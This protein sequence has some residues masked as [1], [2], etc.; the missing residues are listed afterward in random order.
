MKHLRSGWLLVLMVVVVLAGLM[1]PW[2][3]ADTPPAG[4][5][6]PVVVRLYFRDQAH[7]NAVAGELDIWEVHRDA[8]YVVAALRPAEYQWLQ[9]LGYRLEI[10]AEKT[11]L[12]GIQAPLDPRYYYF[13]DYFANS[14]NR[15]IVNFLQDTNAAYPDLTE[16]YDIGNA[17]EGDHGG[18]LRDM[19]VLR[20]TNEDPAYGPI[21][22]K[23]VFYLLA[24]VHAREVATPELAIRYIKYLTSGYN[25]Q[26][27]YNLDPDVTWLV[28][29][30]VAYVLVMQNPD[31]HVVNEQN[32]GAYRRT[33]VD[34]DDGCGDP[35]SWGVD[36]NRNHSFKWG[37]CGGSSGQ[38][39][40]E[41]YRGPSRGSEPETDAFQNHLASVIPDQNG[42]NGDDE[43]PPAAP[44]DT[45]GIFITLHS[46]SDL[47]LWPW[48]HTSNQAPNGAGLQTIGRKF[49]YYNNYTPQQAYQ[50]YATD[51]TTDDWTYGKLGIPSYTFEVGPQS[52][53]C[54]NFF[55]S[56]G[57]IDGIDGMPRNFWA[58]NRP[59]F[60]YAHKIARTPY[61]TAYG[62]DTQNVVVTPNEIPQGAPVSL[63]ANIADH[64]YGG[65]PLQ[66][67]YGAEY[68]FDV[69]GDDG[70][71]IPMA[72]SD[73]SWGG[74]NENVEAT[75]DTSSL[76]PGKHYILVHGLNDDGAWGPFTAVFLT[77]T[78]STAP[79]IIGL[80]AAPASIPIVYGQAT[81]TATLTLS[82][83]T[84]TPG[85]LVTF[86]TD[87]GTLDPIT[88]YS[89]ANGQAVTTLSAGAA[90]GTAHVSAQAASLVGGPAD[91]EIYMPAAPVAEFTAASPACVN[92][93]VAFTNLSTYPP[94]V[95][96]EYLWD[97]GDGM[98]SSTAENPVYA[99]TTG[100][101]LVVSLTAGNV[102]G[103]DTVTHTV[104]ITP[105]PEAAFTYSPSYPQPGQIIH[106]Y[107]ASAGDP[108][109]WS[110]N[111][112]DGGAGSFLQ[113]PIHR[114]TSA[115]TYTV[116]L[117]ARNV[118]GWSD[119]YS[120]TITVGAEPPKLHI[121]LPLVVRD[122]P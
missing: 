117:K 86:T 39:C 78:L 111:F 27:G 114:Y 100:G 40:A 83:G 41:T 3:L 55:P 90:A 109:A 26:G 11:A 95:P 60:L 71:G 107:D 15:Y 106:F 7:L 37:C 30:N 10:D 47:V 8:G 35:N 14:Y 23:P 52:G 66:P 94:E 50:L 45:T 73:G 34:N 31:G 87:L 36:L 51:G 121:Y 67:I 19:R 20:I 38:P 113:N 92:S 116:T 12:L 91:V 105:T 42:P 79:D 93:P 84:P 76:P 96:V 49:A 33:N 75:V 4:P 89:D 44:S 120:Q 25:G 56:Y 119:L 102:G 85:W 9:G 74:L 61:M 103:T 1:G 22:D 97:F 69:P 122:G 62:P 70:T 99:Y 72:P 59:A 43:Y 88:A 46:Y 32:T 118:C 5:S 29:H 53:T 110:W 112:G 57:C 63:T 28:N 21:E 115:G 6:E 81:V 54:G 24:N 101:D 77:T 104:Y 48:G 65:D 82:N 68:F 16:L 98:G 64:R 58:E 108:F 17:W 2:S 80:E 18:Y 13:D